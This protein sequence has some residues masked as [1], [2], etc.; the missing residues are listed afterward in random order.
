MSYNPLKAPDPKE[1]LEISEADRM[2]LVELFHMRTKVKVPNMKLHVTYHVI[3]ENQLAEK[4][5]S[6]VSALERLMG[7]GLDRHDA[8]HAIGNILA[9]HVFRAF[10]EKKP[11]EQQ[12]YDAE[13]DLLTVDYWYKSND[14]TPPK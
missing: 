4:H 14:L 10:K 5:P 7:E 6:A 9:V 1:W 2:D 13:L 12:A 11:M 3:V 8:V